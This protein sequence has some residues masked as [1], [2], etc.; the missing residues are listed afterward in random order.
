MY[1]QQIPHTI[2]GHPLIPKQQK[3]LPLISRTRGCKKL[4][5]NLVAIIVQHVHMCV[6]HI[7]MKGIADK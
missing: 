2:Q 6:A 4:L 7:K 5:W 1:H 3:P